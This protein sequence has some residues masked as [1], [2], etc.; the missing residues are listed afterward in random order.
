MASNN[1]ATTAEKKKA[2]SNIEIAVSAAWRIVGN[3]YHQ[4]RQ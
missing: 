4:Y 2:K 1:V 3:K